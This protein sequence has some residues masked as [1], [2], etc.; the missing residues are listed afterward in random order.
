MNAKDRTLH[1]N[2]V[3]NDLGLAAA[4]MLGVRYGAGDLP[5]ARLDDIVDQLDALFGWTPV[6]S[7]RA[8]DHVAYYYGTEDETF[9]D[10]AYRLISIAQVYN[11]SDEHD[12]RIFMAGYKVFDMCESLYEH[13]VELA[14]KRELLPDGSF[15]D[16]ADD[17]ADPVYENTI[18]SYRYFDR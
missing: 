17:L 1:I 13:C 12:S 2:R 15:G 9:R 16:L 8:R 7:D 6:E 3:T 5:K 10:L 4:A 14:G 11:G 18:A